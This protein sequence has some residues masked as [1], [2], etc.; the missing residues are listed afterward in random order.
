MMTE[1]YS[2]LTRTMMY[3]KSED[4]RRHGAHFPFNF[5]L[6][7]WVD[8]DSSAYKFKEVIDTWLTNM[9]EN[10]AA[11]WVVCNQ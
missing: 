9:P 8:R 3:Y 4:G 10:A 11:N 1:A 6:I 2:N 7:T 5:M